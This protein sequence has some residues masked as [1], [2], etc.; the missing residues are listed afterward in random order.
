MIVVTHDAAVAEACDR[1]IILQPAAPRFEGNLP[2]RGPRR[3]GSR[4]VL[5]VVA[6]LRVLGGSGAAALLVNRRT[7]LTPALAE[8]TIRLRLVTISVSQSSAPKYQVTILYPQLVSSRHSAGLTRFDTLL[9]DAARKPIASFEDGLSTSAL[10]TEFANE[11]S[12]LV[13]T[14]TTNLLDHQFAS[15]SQHL[16]V[17]GGCCSPVR[18][19]QNFQFRR[20]DGKTNSGRRSLSARLR[21]AVC[22]LRREQS[23]VA[24]D[25]WTYHAPRGAGHGNHCRRLELR[26]LGIDTLGSV[27]PVSGVPGGGLRVRTAN[28]RD[29]VRSAPSHCCSRWSARIHRGFT[30]TAVTADP[31]CFRHLWLTSARQSSITQRTATQVLSL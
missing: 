18:H 8:G 5:A 31:R 2:V 9:S 6:L 11:T 13:G 30:P 28:D 29:P 14:A 22:A 25:Y 26:R 4:I 16:A 10:P 3:R 27:D 7:P 19:G 23:A 24:A 21:L 12:M 17:R 15:F 1:T 20:D